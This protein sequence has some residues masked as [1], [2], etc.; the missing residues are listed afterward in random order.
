MDCLTFMSVFV[1]FLHIFVHC[2][3]SKSTDYPPVVRFHIFCR[4]SICNI[5]VTCTGCERFLC[6]QNQRNYFLALS[7]QIPSA[8]FTMT[9][10]GFSF[11]SAQKD[12]NRESRVTVAG[13]ENFTEQNSCSV[14]I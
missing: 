1:T 13:K 7:G 8:S 11:A 12:Q 14:R 2:L 6:T 5:F 10:K 9:H 4:V 3:R